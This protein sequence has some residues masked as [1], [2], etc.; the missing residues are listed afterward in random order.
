VYK[1]TIVRDAEYA[2]RQKRGAPI[3]RVRILEHVRGNRW[4]AHWIDP[5]AGLVHYVESGHLICTWKELKAFLREES[6]ADRLRQDNVECGWVKDSPVDQALY[7]VFENVGDDLSYYRGRLTSK[8]EPLARVKTRAG[9]PVDKSSPYAYT[10]RA[11]T[12]HIPFAEAVEIARRFCA[13][14]P[15]VI[16]ASIEATEQEWAREAALPSECDRAAVGDGAEHAPMLRGQPG[17]LPLDEACPV[18]ANNVGHLAGWPGHRFCRRCERRA[19]SG[20]DT[21]IVSSGFVTA[22][23]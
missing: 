10:D 11:G 17:A 22:C 4:K 6:D 5:N 20:P 7:Q 21:G 19:A 8:P 1:S 15:A 13:A 14:E 12:I 23:K 9:M 2:L 18:L 3:E 16:L